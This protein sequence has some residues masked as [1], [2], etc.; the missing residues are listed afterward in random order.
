MPVVVG[1][2]PDSNRVRAPRTSSF[3]ILP[4]SFHPGRLSSLLPLPLLLLL[5]SLLYILTFG[6]LDPKKERKNELS[7]MKKTERRKRKGRR[8][9]RGVMRRQESRES[10]TKRITL[11]RRGRRRKEREIEREREKSGRRRMKWAEIRGAVQTTLFLN[12]LSDSVSTR[13]ASNRC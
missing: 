7:A 6:T 3:V 4:T 9:K 2:G 1:P 12:H 10:L 8:K 5:L 13:L 11:R